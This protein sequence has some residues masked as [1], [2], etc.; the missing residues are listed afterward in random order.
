MQFLRVSRRKNLRFFPGGQNFSLVLYMIVYQ[1]KNML[2]Q[3]FWVFQ[4]NLFMKATSKTWTWILDPDPE[5]PGPNPEKPGP[6]KNLNPEQPGPWKTWTLKN[7]DPEKHGT[8]I[9][10]K[11]MSDFR[12]LCF[13]N[14]MR[15]VIYCL[16]VR[17][18]TDIEIK[19]F[20]LKIVLATVKWKLWNL[21]F[22]SSNIV[23]WQ[24][25]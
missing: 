22:S 23:C 18:R 7:L 14:T 12:E 16:K 9:G 8:N 19:V 10:L 11:Y 1:P 15:N 25:R 6:T 17:V 3:R 5:K 24:Y 21:R 13:I 20:R 2:L 4:K